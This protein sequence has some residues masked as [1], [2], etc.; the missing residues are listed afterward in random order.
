[1]AN[2]TILTGNLGSD[3]KVFITTTGKTKAVFSLASTLIARDSEG[4]TSKTTAW[5]TIALWGK[6]ADRAVS[7]LRKGSKVLVHG[8]MTSRPFTD[9]DGNDRTAEE[10]VAENFHLLATRQHEAQQ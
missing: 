3:P 8:R 6:R 1:M 2:T 5:H 10:L 7:E 4:N 9:K